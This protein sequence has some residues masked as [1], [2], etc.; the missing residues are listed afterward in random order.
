MLPV[1]I[2]GHAYSQQ[3]DA[4]G[5]FIHLTQVETAPF[6]AHCQNKTAACT[7]SEI[8]KFILKNITG[9]GALPDAQSVEL[10]VRVIIDTLGKVTWA[11]VKGL[12]AAA[13]KE[14]AERL[15]QMAAFSPGEHQGEK[16]NVIVDLKIPLYIWEAENAPAEVVLSEEADEQPLHKKCLK[17]TEPKA[18]TATSIN[19]RMNRSVNTSVIKEPG[20]YSLTAAYVVGVTGKVE[21]IVVHGG[22]PEFALEVIKQ[23]Q[24]LPPLEPGREAGEPVAVSN[25]LPMSL[26]RL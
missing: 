19:D 4:S 24:N 21:R 12:P 17:A 15:K 20:E 16:A 9:I 6:A 25:L 22:G 1:L 10:P 18:C 11:S 13:G 8:E 5:A 3:K 2:T 26:R 14:L 23:L 7:A